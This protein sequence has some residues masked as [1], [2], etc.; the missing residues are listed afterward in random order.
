[1]LEWVAVVRQES[2][3]AHCVLMIM[4]CLPVAVSDENIMARVEG[5]GNNRLER[6]SSMKEF[7]QLYALQ[8]ASRIR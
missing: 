8:S 1:M 3:V 4:K 7:P 6:I 5:S 2:T